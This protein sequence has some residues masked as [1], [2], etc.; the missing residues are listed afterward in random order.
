MPRNTREWA[1]R[2]FDMSEGNLNWAMQ[3][4][5]EIREVYREQHPEVSTPCEEFMTMILLV[6]K[7]V[8][9]LR[10]SI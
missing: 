5:N 7:A 4:L 3:H 6:Q 9:K 10:M 1:Q 2:K 8:V